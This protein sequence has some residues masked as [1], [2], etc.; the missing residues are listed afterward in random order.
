MSKAP[1]KKETRYIDIL[2][3]NLSIS[4][5]YAKYKIYLLLPLSIIIFILGLNL[6][7][8]KILLFI[9]ISLLLISIYDFTYSFIINPR[10]EIK[11]SDDTLIL[12][13]NIIPSVIEEENSYL[14]VKYLYKKIILIKQNESIIISPKV[15]KYLRNNIN[16]I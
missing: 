4:N 10:L 1:D 7:S 14:T 11:P 16:Y 13:K 15:N 3:F 2:K 8:N 12:L 9:S 5:R 6:D